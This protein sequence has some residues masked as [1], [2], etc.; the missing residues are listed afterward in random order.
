MKALQCELKFELEL[1]LLYHRIFGATVTGFGYGY[2]YLSTM[3]CTLRPDCLLHICGLNSLTKFRQVGL[4]LSLFLRGVRGYWNCVP[5]S[6]CRTKEKTQKIKAK[7]NGHKNAKWRR[8][9]SAYD[10]DV[11]VDVDRDVVV[12]GGDPQH[13]LSSNT[14]ES[15]VKKETKYKWRKNNNNKKK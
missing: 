1:Q 14:S 8:L 10:V 9:M 12:D 2:G 4:S 6:D 11:D 7:S 13:P 5:N 3:V 15:W